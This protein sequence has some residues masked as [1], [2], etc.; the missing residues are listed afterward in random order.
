M[1]L[2]PPKEVE[3]AGIRVNQALRRCN[4]ARNQIQEW[5][6]QLAIAEKEFEAAQAAHFDLLNRWDPSTGK[7][8]PSDA[9]CCAET[10]KK[11]V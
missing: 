1:E 10:M 3:T 7:L 5:K 9:E 4:K 6:N 8:R 2:Q 11:A